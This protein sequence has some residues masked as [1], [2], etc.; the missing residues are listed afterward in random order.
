MEVDTEDPRPPRRG[1]LRS[2]SIKN[3]MTYGADGEGKPFVIELQPNINI[4]SGPNGVGKSSIVSAI[5]VCCGAT[6]GFIGR[7]GGRSLGELVKRGADRAEIEI[8][9]YDPLGKNEQIRFKRRLFSAKAHQHLYYVNGDLSSAADYYRRLHD[10]RIKGNNLTQFLPQEQVCEFSKLS[11][12]ELLKQTEEALGA[13]VEEL[14]DELEWHRASWN[15]MEEDIKDLGVAVEQ[16]MEQEG[17]LEKEKKKHQERAGKA[18][19]LLAIRAKMLATELQLLKSAHTQMQE[20][21]ERREKTKKDNIAAATQVVRGVYTESIQPAPVSTPRPGSIHRLLSTVS[22]AQS[23]DGKKAEESSKIR[24]DLAIAMQDPDEVNYRMQLQ[25]LNDEITEL[26]EWIDKEGSVAALQNRQSDFEDRVDKIN[27]DIA[28]VQAASGTIRAYYLDS[29][30]RLVN[31]IEKGFLHNDVLTAWKWLN[32]N[33]PKKVIGPLFFYIWPKTNGYLAQLETAFGKVLSHFICLDK[34]TLLEVFDELKVKKDLK[35]VS[36][37]GPVRTPETPQKEIVDEHKVMMGRLGFT[38]VLS[39][40]FDTIPPVKQFL[41]SYA[42]IGTTLTGLGLDDRQAINL[43]RFWGF[44]SDT[45]T[46]L[47]GVK[48]RCLTKDY[49]FEDKGPNDLETV[50]ATPV[51]QPRLLEYES[52]KAYRA[53]ERQRDEAQEKIRQKKVENDI[54]GADTGDAVADALNAILKEA[55]ENLADA[56]DKIP[57]AEQYTKQLEEK[58]KELAEFSQREKKPHSTVVK[59]YCKRLRDLNAERLKLLCGDSNHSCLQ[60]ISTTVS[61]AFDDCL[62]L[63]SQLITA[64]SCCRYVQNSAKQKAT[65]KELISNGT[66]EM[67]AMQEKVNGREKKLRMFIQTA[68]LNRKKSAADVETMIDR[69]QGKKTAEDL[70]RLAVTAWNDYNSCEMPDYETINR[71]QKRVTEC[72]QMKKDQSEMQFS[73]RK[74]QVS[75]TFLRQQWINKLQGDLAIMNERLRLMF[76][77]IGFDG[78]V[79]LSIPAQEN[80]FDEYGIDLYVSREEGRE[81]ARLT[82]HHQSGGERVVATAVYLMALQGCSDVPFRIV[83]EINQGMDR[84]NEQ[85]VFQLLLETARKYDAQYI[86]VSPKMV[87]DYTGG[88]E[89]INFCFPMKALMSVVVDGATT[90]YPASA[91]TTANVISAYAYDDESDELESDDGDVGNIGKTMNLG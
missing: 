20:D 19:N 69:L 23:A 6:C 16:R 67:N 29:R 15:K 43:F 58:R 83:D 57:L 44:P 41:Q 86:S 80:R 32:E 91:F 45:M 88:N 61:T 47:E 14:H 7:T 39:D 22:N 70:H 53:N 1:I 60:N 55:E 5:M 90:R 35:H 77:R 68:F 18:E 25:T 76:R 42:K 37:I 27:K 28:A 81:M 65:L 51:V 73:L 85:K 64:G 26:E 17:E 54:Q 59:S 62:L 82:R 72:N 49:Q 66:L 75:S 79:E 21:A 52:S 2:I 10:F 48:F 40:L 74:S 8:T 3:F 46:A 12:S 56:T 71:L 13:D 30:K 50:F 24:D 34:E 89:Q 63:I 33:Y 4:L 11:P 36:L 31:L 9:L 78:R 38:K 87:P 84:I